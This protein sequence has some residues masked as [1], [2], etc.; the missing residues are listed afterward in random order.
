MPSASDRPTAL[1]LRGAAG[2]D[3]AEIL[4]KNDEPTRSETVRLRQELVEALEKDMGVSDQTAVI[5]EALELLCAERSADYRR[6]T[7][8]TG[9]RTPP[10]G[11]GRI[12]VRFGTL[13]RE[14]IDALGQ[15]MGLRGRSEVIRAA[16]ELL[17]AERV[18][19]AN[20]EYAAREALST[21]AVPRERDSE[22]VDAEV[23]DAEPAEEGAGRSVLD[24]LREEGGLEEADDELRQEDARRE[25]M[26]WPR[27]GVERTTLRQIRDAKAAAE[28]SLEQA[29]RRDVSDW[30][31]AEALTRAARSYREAAESAEGLATM[32]R[33]AL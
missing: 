18:A 16:L 17:C 7:R 10:A 21:L 13:E 12:S 20:R 4:R 22:P 30:T 11:R 15:E 27:T 26:A 28:R 25:E 6:D 23:V 32:L 2:Q 3:H 5:R 1:R 33:S 24:M 31:R 9:R 14:G 29:L 8:N 19:G